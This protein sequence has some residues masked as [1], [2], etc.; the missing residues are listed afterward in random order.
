MF[1]YVVTLKG[2][3]T[4]HLLRNQSSWKKIQET[5]WCV[6][7]MCDAIVLLHPPRTNAVW[8]RK[9]MSPSLQLNGTRE[10]KNESHQFK[11]HMQN[12]WTN[13][14]FFLFLK[15]QQFVLFRLMTLKKLALVPHQREKE[16]KEELLNCAI[17]T[18][19]ECISHL[20]RSQVLLP[21]RRSSW[22]APALSSFLYY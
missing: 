10:K 1:H 6:T 4:F 7:A 9:R 16:L 12:I 3:N 14:I 15:E 20:S 11:Y 17:G 8:T 13:I 18:F 2:K 21:Y 22:T 19:T 5:L